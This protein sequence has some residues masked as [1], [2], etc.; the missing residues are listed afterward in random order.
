MGYDEVCK[1][2]ERSLVGKTCKNYE[3]TQII[4]NNDEHAASKLPPIVM[5]ITNVIITWWQLEAP[6]NKKTLKDFLEIG[7]FEDFQ[8]EFWF[9]LNF[10]G[11]LL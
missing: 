8:I 3:S 5:Y 9:N 7:N 4:N 10:E 1:K 11:K 2:V 6:S